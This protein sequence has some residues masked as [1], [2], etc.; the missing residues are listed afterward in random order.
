MK[1]VIKSCWNCRYQHLASPSFY[2][3]CLYFET[4][5]K[6]KKEIPS[7]IVEVGCL[8]HKFDDSN[9]KRSAVKK[10]LKI[11]FGVPN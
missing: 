2:G 7:K 9:D 3:D 1:N 4:V 8:L 10:K 11:L 6:K 5:G